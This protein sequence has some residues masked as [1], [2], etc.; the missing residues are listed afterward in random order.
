MYVYVCT[1]MYTQ[2]PPLHINTIIRAGHI[3]KGRIEGWLPVGVIARWQSIGTESQGPGFES[4][5]LHLSF[6]ALAF[7]VVYGCKG[8][9]S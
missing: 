1:N 4:Q 3:Q 7:S 9:N 5:R 8:T 2:Q 6:L